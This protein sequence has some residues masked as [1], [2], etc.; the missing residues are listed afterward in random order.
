MC[1]EQTQLIQPSGLAIIQASCA[2]SGELALARIDFGFDQNAFKDALP[3]FHCVD[4]PYIARL[5]EI[6]GFELLP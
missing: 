6:I 4:S 3:K 5:E 2:S 1:S